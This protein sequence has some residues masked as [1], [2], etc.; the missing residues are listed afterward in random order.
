MLRSRNYFIES[1]FPS[2]SDVE[3]VLKALENAPDGLS[4]REI[5]AATDVSSGRIRKTLLLLSL[6][7]PAPVAKLG[8]KWQLT[9]A[10]LGNAFWERVNR[11]TKLRRREQAQMQEYVQLTSGHME[12]LIRALD[13][14]PSDPHPTAAQALPASAD[15]DCVRKA[16][17]FLRGW[18]RKILPR[19]QWPP[20]K[21]I[22]PDHRAEPGIALCAW[23]D[24]GWGS[25]V[26]QGKYVD[27]HISDELVEACATLVRQWRPDPF[28]EW[29]T[30]VPS[31]RRPDLV[32][33]FAQRLA[34]A[35]ELPFRTALTKT[36][37][38][39]EQK[40]MTNSDKQARNVLGSLDV[41]R[42]AILPEPV[43]LV[44]DIVDSRWT[45]TV[46]AWELRRR[47]CGK[48]W[49]L[50]LAAVGNA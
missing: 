19:R 47:G 36:E 4:V 33:D 38:R 10:T 29:A 32:P 43:L 13:G 35:L 37:H 46:V 45:F 1:A 16:I 2:Q 40:S 6:E 30:A 25:L 8:A 9:A 49:P 20:G 15:P 28:P 18:K 27:E 34:A 50:A 14:D 7:S 21:T 44:D 5:E 17:T 39:P 3:S 26:R 31:L 23:G 41:H 12:F 48:V 22:S 24:A 42:G 11:L